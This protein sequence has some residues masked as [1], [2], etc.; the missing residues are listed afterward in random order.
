MF[1]N[2]LTRRNNPRVRPTHIFL[3]DKTM[4]QGDLSVHLKTAVVG[5][6]VAAALALAGCGKKDE[7]IKIGHAGPLTGPVA[8]LGKDNENG[9]RLAL[10]EANAAS[11]MIGGKKAV[12]A[13]QSEDDQADPK[14]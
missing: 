1:D 8:H 12:F 6:A 5:V 7:T 10:D 3:E 4:K 11:I 14:Q 2:S 9:V 13:M